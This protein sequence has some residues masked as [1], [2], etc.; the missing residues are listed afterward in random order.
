M[1]VARATRSIN[2]P[3]L[4]GTALAVCAPLAAFAL[5]VE[6]RLTTV[7]QHITAEGH[8]PVLARLLAVEKE[9][10]RAGQQSADI[11]RRMDEQTALLREISARIERLQQ[12]PRR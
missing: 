8:P 4:I 3:Q 9:S 6:T 10:A 12:Q 7:E 2:W 5:R 1:T 11:V